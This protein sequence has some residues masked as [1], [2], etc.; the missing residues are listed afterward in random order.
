MWWCPTGPLA[1]L[2]IHAAGI[3]PSGPKLSDFV[4]SSYTP[5]L[6]A[7]LDKTQ[8]PRTVEKHQFLTVALPTESR[9][10]GTKTEIENIEKYCHKFPVLRLFESE[11]TSQRVS[12]GMKSSHWVHFACHGAQN[13]SNPTES[14][15]LLAGRSKLTL[16]EMIK[17]S[18]TNAELA[19]LSACETATGD[20]S[21]EEEAVHIAAGMMLAG[22]RGVIATMWT[23]NDE[24]AVKVA[25]ETYRRLFKEYGADST[26]AAEALH[27]AV[28]KVCKD[29]SENLPL[30]SWLPFIHMG[31]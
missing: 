31:N 12:E 10:P 13:N 24:V 14:C 29:A 2:P 4:V 16:A 25:S 19:F 17:L 5:T 11:A 6:N 22:Y 3:Y 9:L 15:L 18:L 27:Y 26:Q 20:K 30:F 1:F 7:L 23:I 8:I 21:L 28:K